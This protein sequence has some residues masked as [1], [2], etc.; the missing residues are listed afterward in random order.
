[1][2]A[3]QL[4]DSEY[5]RQ[6]I[7]ELVAANQLKDSQIKELIFKISELE[8]KQSERYELKHQLE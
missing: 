2:L 7:D 3:S 6:T 8:E 5:L 4:Q 1:M